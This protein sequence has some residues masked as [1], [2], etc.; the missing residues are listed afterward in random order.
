MATPETVE[1][2]TPAVPSLASPEPTAA[3]RGGSLRIGLGSNPRSIDP[4]FADDQDGLLVVDALFDSLTRH[5][6]ELTPVPS[7]AIAWRVSEDARTWTF[8]LDSQATFH[9]GSLVSASDFVR[10]F[11]RIADGRATPRSF[12]AHLLRDVVGWAEAQAKGVPLAGVR[13]T[14]LGEFEIQLLRPNADLAD[15]LVHPSLAPVPSGADERPGWASSPVGNGPFAM[16]EPWAPNQFIRLVRASS[17]PVLDEV[18][19]RIYADDLG[20]ARQFLDFEAGQLHVAQVPSGSLVAALEQYGSAGD[21]A[22]GAGVIDGAWA[23]TYDYGFDTT[24]APFDVAEVRQAVSLLIDRERIASEVM[25]GTRDAA[26]GLLPLG[27]LGA[28]P[29]TCPWC[30][31]APEEARQLL[32]DAGI[33]LDPEVI[34]PLV[35]IHNQ[36]STHAQ[37]AALI[38]TSIT[39]EL[40]LELEVRELGLQE[41]AQALRNHEGHLF[42]MGWT[43][44]HPMASSYLEPI[45]ATSSLGGDN[46]TGFSDLQTDQLLRQSASTLER[47]ERVLLG[48]Q[49]QQRVA[50][51]APLA[52][53]LDYRLYRVV[54]LRV[55]DFVMNP[56][57]RVD[58]ARVSLVPAS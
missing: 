17:R 36:G 47:S 43:S 56:M 23:T 42:R 5:D 53:V 40:G 16:A 18:L 14:S 25:L 6:G 58:L 46:V 34:G 15:I 24:R 26:T 28:E 49:V 38:A 30:R 7:A 55:R 19:F 20:N 8:T 35:L 52:P 10:A 12:Q 2:R 33:V 21:G 54:D 13:S 9:D 29:R 37:I 57:A 39:A 27:L 45:F 3:S 11:Q 1:S 31:F 44:E 41:Y 51:L 50:Q 4:R 22:D 48:Q 32:E